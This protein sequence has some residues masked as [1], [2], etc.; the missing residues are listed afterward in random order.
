MCIFQCAVLHCVVWADFRRSPEERG[1]CRGDCGDRAGGPARPRSERLSHCAELQG[2]GWHELPL[3]H[4]A[5]FQV[6]THLGLLLEAPM[7]NTEW[8]ISIY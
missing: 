7:F 8:G 1:L 6:Q 3:Q 5:M 2:A 4:T